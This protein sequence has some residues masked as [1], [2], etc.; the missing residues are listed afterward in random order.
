MTNPILAALRGDHLPRRREIVKTQPSQKMLEQKLYLYPDYLNP[1]IATDPDVYSAIR[2]G[3]LVHGPGAT[4]MTYRAWHYE[5]SNS[6]VFACL[7]AI[8]TA[9]PEVSAKV[10][11][12]KADNPGE[13]DEQPDHPLKLLLDKPNPYLSRENMWFYVQYCKHVSGNA[14]WRKVRS[15]GGN[16]LSLW[17]ISPTRIQPVT[18]KEDAARG[19]FISWYAYTFDPAQ[20]PERIPPEDIVHFRLGL[21]DK[22]HRVG[23]SPLAKLVREVAG[24]DEAHQWQTTMLE[25]GGSIGMLVEVPENSTITTEGAE[26]LK[27]DLQERFTGNNRGKVG[28]LTAG[29]TAKPYGF[30]PSDMDM[31]ALHRIPE[32]RIAAVLRVPAIIAGLGAGLDRST[33]SNFR[34]AREMF[35]E[36]CM[37]P[38]YSFD[39]A[40]L[41]MQ[42]TPEFTSDPKIKVDFELTD[43]RAMQEDE[44]AKF[45]RLNEAVKTGWVRPNEARTEVGLPPDMD[46]LEVPMPKLPMMGAP[47]E[48]G[49]PEEKQRWHQPKPPSRRAMRMLP[50]V[51]QAF[52]DVATPGLQEDLE[53]YFEGQQQRVNGN[54][55]NA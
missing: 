50:D 2:M 25:N 19:V 16:V 34:E 18:I 5:D 8:A 30:S 55:T 23:I 38:L 47:Q 26:Q 49:E 40:T 39:A 1:S 21:D 37:L 35:A 53:G 29:A 15:S 22:D 32:E 28:V 43:L 52:V 36:M 54:L 10:Y 24:D 13:K 12:E 41:N 11:L 33:Y 3:T 46:E 17:P 14:Y 7:T 48:E 20:D 51:L 27:L 44:D 6:A 4:E 45:K 42:L 31:K 9:Y